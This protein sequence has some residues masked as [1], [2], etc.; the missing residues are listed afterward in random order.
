MYIPRSLS[1]QREIKHKSM[2]ISRSLSSQRKIHQAYTNKDSSFFN[3]KRE[4]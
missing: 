2:N 1:T 3:S 4:M